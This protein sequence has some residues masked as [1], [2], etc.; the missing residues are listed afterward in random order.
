MLEEVRQRASSND[1]SASA[2]AGSGGP[3]SR[4]TLPDPLPIGWRRRT[5]PAVC[6]ALLGRR[7]FGLCEGGTE[8][9]SRCLFSRRDADNRISLGEPVLP[10]A[11]CNAG[12][13][14]GEPLGW[15][16]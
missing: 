1:T 4:P 2:Y 10:N 3:L 11:D 14:R 9:G 15:R 8:H 5:L 12:K 16:F 13:C 6:L 7:P